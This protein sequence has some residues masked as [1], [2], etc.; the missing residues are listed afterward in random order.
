MVTKN[1]HF[2]E[3]K[4]HSFYLKLQNL[5]RLLVFYFKLKEVSLPA[6]HHIAKS[7]FHF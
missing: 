3:K 6:L 2:R 4:K 7:A 5:N 1:N